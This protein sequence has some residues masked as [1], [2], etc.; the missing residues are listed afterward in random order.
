MNKSTKEHLVPVAIGQRGK[1]LV[2]ALLPNNAS[3]D[4][5]V[6]DG[7]IMQPVFVYTVYMQHANGNSDVKWKMILD[8][9]FHRQF[10]D[11][12]NSEDMIEHKDW[13]RTFVDRE[14]PFSEE[15]LK[16]IGLSQKEIYGRSKKSDG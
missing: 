11:A 14:L 16:S 7:S 15:S 9:K 5:Y 3:H 12:Q 2:V 13:T 8:T 10:W 6:I 1:T 4:G